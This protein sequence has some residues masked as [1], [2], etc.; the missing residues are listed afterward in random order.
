MNVKGKQLSL[1]LMALTGYGYSQGVSAQMPAVEQTLYAL[2]SQKSFAGPE[3]LFTGQVQVEM[4]F[5]EKEQAHFSAAYVTFAPGA[6]TA[7]HT[8]P[9]GQHMIVT[10][11]IALTGTRDGNVIEFSAGE[12][13]WCPPDIDHWHGATPH[14]PMTH[15]VITGSRD[16][17]NVVWK[18]KVTDAEYGLTERTKAAASF[19]A[20]NAREQALIP[21]TAYTATGNLAALEQALAAG[22]DAGLTINEVRGVQ[23]HLY[24]Y[25]GFPR[26]LN[27]LVTLM[28]V[29]DARKAAGVEDAVGAAPAAIG[30]GESS[31]V[32]GERV[33][34]ELVGQ[35]VAGLLFDFAPGMNTF[36]QSHLFGDLFA[37][38]VLDYQQRELVT[39]AALASMSGTESQLGSH[40]RMATNVGVSEQQLTE[41][42]TLLRTRVGKAE[43][44]RVDDAIQRILHP[45]G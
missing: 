34:T 16:G 33:Q 26:A 39:V 23:V 3:H 43:G 36:L 22:L 7:W 5:P 27:G 6:R 35:P 13:V 18:E 30:A 4:L 31:Q 40:I 24:A 12:T 19:E 2:G 11:G 28:K 32:V 37:R 17:K 25:S 45:Q 9:A 8:H 15:L 1:M 29:I 20:L 44:L 38:G 41:L 14:A 42:A 21:I 10:E